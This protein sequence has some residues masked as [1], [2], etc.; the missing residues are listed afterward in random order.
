MIHIL[1]ELHA[2]HE[3]ETAMA[4]HAVTLAYVDEFDFL[5]GQ[6][7]RL[8]LLAECFHILKPDGVERIIQ[9]GTLCQ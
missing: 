9:Q 3:W 5:T 7:Y 8:D 4:D 6:G 1:D 2:V